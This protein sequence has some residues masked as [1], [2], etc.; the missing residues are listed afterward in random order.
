MNVSIGDVWSND[1]GDSLVVTGV[2]LLKGNISK[3]LIEW[4]S[5]ASSPPPQLTQIEFTLKQ[6]ECYVHNFRLKCLPG[7]EVDTTTMFF[8]DKLELVDQA[9]KENEAK[10]KFL[11]ETRE[12]MRS[13]MI[14]ERA[15]AATKD[16]SIEEICQLSDCIRDHLHQE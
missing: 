15:D 12:S 4:T 7:K 1:E 16:L 6:F 3:V 10:L 8:A 5:R 2:W 13:K 14:K 9:I 11:K